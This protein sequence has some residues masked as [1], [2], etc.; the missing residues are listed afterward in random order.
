MKNET[1]NQ[2]AENSPQIEK[3]KNNYLIPTSIFLSILMIAGA[4]VYSTG[5]NA[6]QK[7]TVA[8]NLSDSE[9][10]LEEKVL[11]SNGVVLPVKWEGLGKQ[12]V[13]SGA[14]DAKKFE[15]IY[16]SRGG[17]SNEDKNLLYGE[18]NGNLI[19]NE[20]N[21]G[22]ILN[23]LWAFGLANKNEILDNGEM[24]DPRYGGAGGFAST[25][26]WTLA[27]GDAMSYYSRYQ[28]IV[29]TPEQQKLV[30]EASKNI[31][32]PCCNNSTHFPDCNHGMAMLGLLE[33]MAS[34]GL[35]EE[36]MYKTALQVNAYWF[37]ETYLTIAK[38]FEN[39][40]VSWDRVNA[41]EILGFD[42]SSGSG[43]QNL[44]QKIKPEEIKGG[45]SCG[46]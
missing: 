4:W 27:K 45:G 35:S 17:L 46:V 1:E 2:T 41:K 36:E 16:E 32:R 9:L 18:N 13:E 20:K 29:L 10:T 34:Q 37:P 3:A 6:S 8:V 5:Y 42:Y 14:I 43:Y 21:S 24:V 22:L 30:D 15:M 11:P 7:K 25:G 12:L 33:L 19:I 23:L 44:L 38:Y 39:Q 26:G 28:F 31:Y 40:D